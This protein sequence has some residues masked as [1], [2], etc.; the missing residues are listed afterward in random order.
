MFIAY[1]I[2]TISFLGRFIALEAMTFDFEYLLIPNLIILNVKKKETRTKKTEQTE[3]WFLLFLYLIYLIL[4]F[5][6]SVHKLWGSLNNEIINNK[7]FTLGLDSVLGS[8][9]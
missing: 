8:A 1:R 4:M 6:K 3:L 5:N 2:V 7:L 9:T